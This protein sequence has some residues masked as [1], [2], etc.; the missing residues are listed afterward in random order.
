MASSNAQPQ[1]EAQRQVNRDEVKTLAIAIGVREAARKL[2]LN[3]NTV[4]QW[5]RRQGWFKQPEPK[6]IP[7]TI[8]KQQGNSVT[9]VTKPSDALRSALDDDSRETRLN[10]SKGAR[11]A[12]KLFGEAPGE[13]TVA[14]S[15]DFRRIVSSAA[16]IHNWQEAERGSG[17]MPGLNIYSEQTVIQ[18]GKG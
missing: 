9:S 16:Q 12:A 5:S 1:R 17:V 11:S 8:V 13:F 15:E 18:V 3:E 6:P 10:L 7:A 2:G 4:R 14:R